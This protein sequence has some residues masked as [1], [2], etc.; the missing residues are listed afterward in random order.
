MK[1]A[2]IIILLAWIIL[3]MF[4][5]LFPPFEE[6]YR[7]GNV[8]VIKPIPYSLVE[9]SIFDPPTSRSRI[10]GYT[11]DMSRA[12]LMISSVSVLPIAFIIFT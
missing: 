5:C 7:D 9:Y 8:K 12:G 2:Q 6:F 3:T 10:I 11:V 1:V 4:I